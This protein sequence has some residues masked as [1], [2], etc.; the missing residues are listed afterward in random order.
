MKSIGYMIKQIAAAHAHDLNELFKQHDLTASQGFVLIYLLKADKKQIEVTQRDI[1]KQFDISNPTVSGIL[2]RLQSKE[3]IE[4]IVSQEDARKKI[5]RVSAKARCLD[6][7]LKQGFK[8]CDDKILAC[9]DEQE[10]QLLLSLLDKVMNEYIGGK[11]VCG[12]RL[13]EF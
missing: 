12:K 10:E 7:N 6:N 4:R 1:E 9:L 8:L 2:D 11:H 5:V 3:L 13:K